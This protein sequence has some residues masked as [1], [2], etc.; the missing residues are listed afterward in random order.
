MISPSFTIPGIFIISSK[1]RSTGRHATEF[2]KETFSPAPGRN[3]HVTVSIGLA[4]YRPQEEMKAFV[5][6]VDQLI[7]QGKKN[8]KD[9]VCC[10]S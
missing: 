4:Q 1:W 7:Y 5:H 3:V 9:R 10:E 8:G 6:R 2:K